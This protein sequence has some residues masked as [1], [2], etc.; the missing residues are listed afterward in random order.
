MK[1]QVSRTTRVAKVRRKTL[2]TDIEVRLTLDGAGKSQVSTGIGFLDHMLCSLAKHARFDLAVSCKGDLQVDDH[3]SSEDVALTL[4]EALDAA[5][6][7]AGSRLRVRLRALDLAR[8]V[9]D[10]SAGPIQPSI[11][12]KREMI[13]NWACEHPV[14]PIAGGHP[15][16]A[17]HVDVLKENDHHRGGRVQGGGATLR[18]SARRDKT[19]PSTGTLR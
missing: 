18:Q 12:A 13:G 5:L 3:H 7:D 14:L 8:V 16:C 15:R 19:V 10:L 11:S 4:G 6:G 1:N 9:V 2:E 17:L